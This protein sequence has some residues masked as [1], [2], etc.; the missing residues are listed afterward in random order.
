[1]VQILLVED[2]LGD[3]LLV[4]RA[5]EEHGIAHEMHVVRD[6]AEALAFLS[7]I[8]QPGG[9]PC[10][11]LLLLD[12]NLPKVEGPAVLR[13]FRAHAQCA[14][15]PVIVVTSADTAKDRARVAELGV[16]RY[17]KK[18]SDLDAFLQLGAVVREVTQPR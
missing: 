7:R 6:G 2:N 8:G 1:M 12:L 18:P 4:Q 16:D 13:Q 14:T 11:D 9:T 3:I 10:P 17:F 5:L 15:T